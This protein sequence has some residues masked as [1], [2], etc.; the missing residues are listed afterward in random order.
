MIKPSVPLISVLPFLALAAVCVACAQLAGQPGSPATA[1]VPRPVPVTSSPSTAAPTVVATSGEP[2]VIVVRTPPPSAPTAVVGGLVRQVD[3]HI[4]VCAS[5]T[6]ATVGG[7]L[8]VRARVLDVGLPDCQVLL[9]DE[10]TSNAVVLVDIR[11][12]N[13]VKSQADASQV[14][15]FVSGDGCGDELVATL[16]GR[17]AGRTQLSV[18]ANGEVDYGASGSI[19]WSGKSEPLAITVTE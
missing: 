12:D 3:P 19:L 8:T 7:T 9:Q 10:G 15:S 18:A 13:K 17:R 11:Y 14:L 16:R 6:M 2:C 4:E 5:A 1:S